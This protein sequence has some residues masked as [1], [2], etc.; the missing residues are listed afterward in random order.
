MIGLCFNESTWNYFKKDLEDGRTDSGMNRGLFS[1]HSLYLLYWSTHRL[2]PVVPAAY[3]RLHPTADGLME[4]PRLSRM[5]LAAAY[6][7]EFSLRWGAL[8]EGP[9]HSERCYDDGKGALV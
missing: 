2:K 6:Q 7:S 8:G 9:T 5:A 4:R 1:I 3:Q